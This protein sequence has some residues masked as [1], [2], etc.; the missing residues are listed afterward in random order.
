MYKLI[1]FSVLLF[2]LSAEGKYYEKRRGE[3]GYKFQ[4]DLDDSR[5]CK[6]HC[7]DTK[8]S[9]KIS[10]AVVDMVIANNYS[11]QLLKDLM[12]PEFMTSNIVYDQFSDNIKDSDYYFYEGFEHLQQLVARY[13]VCDN[14]CK[15]YAE[16]RKNIRENAANAETYIAPKGDGTSKLMISGNFV[17]LDD[18]LPDLEVYFT[19]YN[20]SELYLEANAFVIN[21]NLLNPSWHG[22]TVEI[23]SYYIYVS[24]EVSWDVSAAT[25]K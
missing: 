18:I 3:D 7:L 13:R 1:I 12:I 15:V 20:I 21:D 16:L 4:L 2:V 19:E 6:D 17:I 22:K 5:C 25:G 8:N 10:Q 14:V 9:K 11:I 23:V 24:Q